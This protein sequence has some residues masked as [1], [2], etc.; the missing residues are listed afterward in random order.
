MVALSSGELVMENGSKITKCKVMKPSLPPVNIGNG[1]TFT[2]NG[3][4][5]SGNSGVGRAVNLISTGNGSATFRMNGGEISNNR[6]MTGVGEKGTVI[7]TGGTI[8]NNKAGIHLT[9]GSINAANSVISNNEGWGIEFPEE[10][11]GSINNVT[12]NGN[13]KG[14]FIG[15]STFTMNGGTISGNTEDGDIT[16]GIRIGI[17]GSFI[18]NGS[19]TI[20]DQFGLYTAGKGGN[21]KGMNGVIYLGTDFSPAGGTSSITVNLLG[22]KDNVKDTTYGWKKSGGKV[23]LRGGTPDSPGT[24][25]IAQFQNFRG[26]KVYNTKPELVSETV[27]LTHKDNLGYAGY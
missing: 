16:E 25:T 6:D 24:V 8:S 12:I 13:G 27:N 23:F 9:S 3:G 7:M 20:G 26:G 1:C 22:G 15:N 5:I 14:V 2:M 17:T 4:A 21:S 19:V 10:V 18:I 11:N